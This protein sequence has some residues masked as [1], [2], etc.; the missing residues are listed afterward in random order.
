M[1]D[2]S[3]NNGID[4]GVSVASMLFWEVGAAY[5]GGKS[6]FELTRANTNY[7]MNNGINPGMQF[8]INKE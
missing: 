5:Y 8:I 2:Q 3:M 7:L 1:N 6:F 4:L